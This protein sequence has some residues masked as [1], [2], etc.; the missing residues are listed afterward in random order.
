MRRCP[1]RWRISRSIGV[2]SRSTARSTRPPRRGALASRGLIARMPLARPS[3]PST[4]ACPSRSSRPS[5]PFFLRRCPLHDALPP[6]ADARAQSSHPQIVPSTNRPIHTMDGLVQLSARISLPLEISEDPLPAPLS[7]S[8]TKAD[9]S[10][11]RPEQERGKSGARAEQERGK[12]G[13]R[14]GHAASTARPSTQVS[15]CCASLQSIICFA[16][17]P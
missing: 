9:E 15:W 7:L 12:S 4:A 11:C 5:R 1:L 16:N 17:T 10:G 13:A 6:R 3:H 14:A 2:R 8:A